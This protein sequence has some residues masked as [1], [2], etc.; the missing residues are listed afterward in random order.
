MNYLIHFETKFHHAQHYIGY[1]RDGRLQKRL[2]EHAE[3][4]TQGSKLVAAVVRA[5]IRIVVSRT[6]D[7]A[8]R[9]DERILHRRKNSKQ[10]CPIC[11]GQRT[12]EEAISG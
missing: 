8:T 12:F 6:W 10:L 1:C 5:G 7:K 4:A 2:K 11:L 9:D 3:T